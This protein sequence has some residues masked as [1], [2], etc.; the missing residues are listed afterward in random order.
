MRFHTVVALSAVALA[1][2]T[3]AMPVLDSR[4]TFEYSEEFTRDLE[5]LDERGAGKAFLIAGPLG[6]AFHAARKYFKNRK[7]KKAAT[8]DNSANVGPPQGPPPPYTADP[9]VPRE[10]YWEEPDARDLDELETRELL[11]FWEAPE[12]RTIPGLSPE[13]HAAISALLAQVHQHLGI[14]QP[15]SAPP[16]SAPGEAAH[17]E[18][19]AESSHSLAEPGPPTCNK[20][21]HHQQMRPQACANLPNMTGYKYNRECHSKA[22]TASLSSNVM[23]ACYFG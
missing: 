1:A 18:S 2:T 12:A 13:H 21:G 9:P 14:P 11:N 15:G 7:A 4:D 6:L 10:L 20:S 19:H 8:A 5:T 16:G 23:G 22:T 17:E 3:A